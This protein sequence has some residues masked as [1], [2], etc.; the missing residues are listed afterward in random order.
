MAPSKWRGSLN[1]LFQLAITIGILLANLVNSTT[2]KMKSNG[3]RVSLAIAMIP[4]VLITIG[5]IILPNTPNSLVQRG[6]LNNG[7]KV[8]KHIRGVEDVDQE[9]QD[10]MTASQEA[11]AMEQSAF[12]NV[13]KRHNRPQLIISVFLQFFQQFTGIN[14]I[15]FYAPVL[16]QTVGFGSSAALYSSVIVGAVNVLSTLVAIFLVDRKGRRWLLLEACIQMIVAQVCFSI[17]YS[18]FI[19]YSCKCIF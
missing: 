15:M 17:H 6:K 18:L 1:S 5:G 12:R 3:W 9:F 13:I 7:R 16:F 8:L 19:S 14:A 2:Q 10:I 4:A 11:V